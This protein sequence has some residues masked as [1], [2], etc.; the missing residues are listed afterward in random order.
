M[1]KKI[2]RSLE[3][4]ETVSVDLRVFRISPSSGISIICRAD[5]SGAACHRRQ[6]S[7]HQMME[8]PLNGA[9]YDW[10]LNLQTLEERVINRWKSFLTAIIW[11]VVTASW[12]P[13][14]CTL[15]YYISSSLLLYNTPTVQYVCTVK[16]DL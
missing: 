2:C 5:S 6:L 9:K 8:M 1:K 3:I 4:E 12:L 10:L 14:L 16:L 11:E 7:A 15:P 13:I